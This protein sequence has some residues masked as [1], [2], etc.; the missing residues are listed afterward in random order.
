MGGNLFKVDFETKKGHLKFGSEETKLSQ[1]SRLK[2]PT[3][4]ENEWSLRADLAV[5]D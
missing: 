5:S 3:S 1:R 4:N 2:D